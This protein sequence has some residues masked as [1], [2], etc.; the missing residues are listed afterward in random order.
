MAQRKQ[1]P[2]LTK[3]IVAICVVAGAILAVLR[4]A[5][6][7]GTDY[8]AG[9]EVAAASNH[10]SLAKAEELL[11]SG[12][13]GEANEVLVPILDQLEPDSALTS[14]ALLLQAKLD[15]QQG[16]RDAA[17]AGFKRVTEEFP[18]SPERPEAAAAYGRLLEEDGATGQA[19]ALYKGIADS[20]P[21]EV[22]APAVNG[23]ARAKEREGDLLGAR[24]LY[25]QVTREAPWGSQAWLNAVEA[26][27]DINTKLIFSVEPTPES[28]S[29]RVE[30]GD[31]FTKIGV[32]L[33]TTLGLLTRANGLREDSILRLDQML[34]YTPKDFHI[35]IERSTCRLFLLDNDGIFKMYR[36]GLGKPGHD[37]TLGR[38]RIGNKEKDPTWHK[39]GSTPIP[40]GDP[41]NE[42]GS[43]WMPMVPEEQGLPNDL[44]IHGTIAPDTI[45]TY[46]SRG[47]PRLHNAE[48]EELYDLVVRSTPVTVVETFVREDFFG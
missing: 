39:P 7:Y 1:D 26:L 12:N 27:G 36:I 22:R 14:R 40:P 10:E 28:K 46:A 25:A 4:F 34:K 48:V 41:E 9:N 42:L 45:G 8:I 6:W 17:L 32:K 33:N 16:N 15:L 13:P 38:Y 19:L 44:G 31:S 2:S 23:L 35:V 24:E 5:D 43:R 30:A 20:A 11:A 47:C 21:R 29:Y 3:I 37:T 18:A